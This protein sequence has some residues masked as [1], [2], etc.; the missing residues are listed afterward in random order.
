MI[1]L[2]E[3]TG[4]V[5]L[6]KYAEYRQVGVNDKPIRVTCPECKR[7]LMSHVWTCSALCCVAHYIPPHKPKNWWTIGKPRK[8]NKDKGNKRGH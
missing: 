7:R 8:V 3:H 4:K 5:E 6:G 2:C 1:E